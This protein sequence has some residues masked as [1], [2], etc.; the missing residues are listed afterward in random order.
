VDG[1]PELAHPRQTHTQRWRGAAPCQEHHAV[2]KLFRHPTL[3]AFNKLILIPRLAAGNGSRV[4]LRS[5]IAAEI[6]LF[7]GVMGTTAHLVTYLSP[8]DAADAAHAHLGEIAVS[9]PIG[10]IQPWAPAMPGGA[11]TGA[12][13]LVIV[14][15]QPVADRLLAASNIARMRELTALR[16]PAGGRLSLRG[17]FRLRAE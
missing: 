4:W 15:N 13:Y 9:G 3:A 8:H 17:R 7:A 6:L 10:I 16:V 12:G 2:R 11:Q 1:H 5:M 14:N